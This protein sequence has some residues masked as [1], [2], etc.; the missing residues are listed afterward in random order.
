MGRSRVSTL[1]D[2]RQ[3]PR[4]QVISSLQF[5]L[6][7]D[8]LDDDCLL[9]VLAFIEPGSRDA[10]HLSHLSKRYRH[11]ALST[12]HLWSTIRWVDYE[13][14]SSHPAQRW[15]DL[16]LV[17]A[18]STVDL[19]VEL[20]ATSTSPRAHVNRRRICNR[21]DR[22]AVFAR[23]CAFKLVTRQD[24]WSPWLDTILRTP[25]PKLRRLDV[26]AVQINPD[27]RPLARID[28]P[29]LVSVSLRGAAARL[30]VQG[31]PLPS[32]KGLLLNVR[33]AE[34]SYDLSRHRDW[35]RDITGLLPSLE[36]LRVWEDKS[37]RFRLSGT[38]NQ[39]AG[40]ALRR[41]VIIPTSDSPCLLNL[42]T[43]SSPRLSKIE[44]IFTGYVSSLNA[45]DFSGILAF[46]MNVRTRSAATFEV[47]RVVIKGA[48][49]QSPGYSSS[50]KEQVAFFERKREAQDLGIHV[51]VSFHDP[52]ESRT[53]RRGTRTPDFDVGVRLVET[54][55]TCAN[56]RASEVEV[57]L[58]GN[59][60]W[61]L[62]VSFFRP[63][64][65]GAPKLSKVT[66]ITLHVPSPTEA[67]RFVAVPRS[68][69]DVPRVL[70]VGLREVVL[71][72]PVGR[73]VLL[74]V[75]GAN[76]LMAKFIGMTEPPR[77]N[78]IG[79]LITS[80]EDQDSDYE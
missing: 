71:R 3:L 11:I 79:V 66:K 34:L 2:I 51:C 32:L 30:V 49:M 46:M 5:D 77:L 47:A 65:G 73:A 76:E 50:G 16:L 78:L 52:R 61:R 28:M 53:W 37:N 72:A 23:V 74:S 80:P 20:E 36:E 25:M 64:G 68:W 24:T 57:E 29:A 75:G 40:H 39:D 26:T 9:L 35:L 69:D 1:L 8:K 44:D 38:R 12:P 7:L 13:G 63:K 18:G 67:T 31:Q 58:D 56:Q 60:A 4:A 45:G 22:H 41:L 15:F 10:I 59:D 55:F 19:S 17:R 42:D 21:F 62:L 14:S 54:A 48:S 70:M 33:F 6:V 27:F 43:A